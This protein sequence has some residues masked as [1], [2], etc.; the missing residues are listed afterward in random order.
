M[1][2]NAHNRF[3]QPICI[4]PNRRTERFSTLPS[5]IRRHDAKRK[6]DHTR[7]CSQPEDEETRK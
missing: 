5:M 4:T 6:M 3:R 2:R 7:F 1:E